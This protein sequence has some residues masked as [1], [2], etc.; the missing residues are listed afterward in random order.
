MGKYEALRDYLAARPGGEELMTFGQVK[1]LVP[2]VSGKRRL[3]IPVDRLAGRRQ[4]CHISRP[5]LRPA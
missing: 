5:G 1:R 2:R 3:Q 4:A